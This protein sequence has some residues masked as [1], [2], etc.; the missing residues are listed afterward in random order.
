VIGILTNILLASF[1]AVRYISLHTA[2]G[3]ASFKIRLN[4]IHQ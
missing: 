3:A 4:R 2:A 1:T